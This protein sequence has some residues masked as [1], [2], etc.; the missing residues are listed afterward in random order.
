MRTSNL[1]EKIHKNLFYK[2][3]IYFIRLSLLVGYYIKV[4]I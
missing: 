4:I 1:G 3:L 2:L